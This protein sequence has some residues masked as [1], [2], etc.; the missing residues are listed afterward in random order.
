MQGLEHRQETQASAVGNSHSRFCW[1]RGRSDSRPNGAAKIC[2]KRSLTFRVNCM[3]MSQF[4]PLVCVY[5]WFLQTILTATIQPASIRVY[6]ISTNAVVLAYRDHTIHMQRWSRHH[7][8]NFSTNASRSWMWFPRTWSW[9]RSSD[10][11]RTWIWLWS[12]CCWCKRWTLTVQWCAWR[13]TA[14]ERHPRTKLNAKMFSSQSVSR[15][16]VHAMYTLVLFANMGY[17]CVTSRY[18]KTYYPCAITL[19][20]SI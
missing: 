9:T 3:L 14:T 8:N 13:H 12:P 10:L 19:I 5:T 6:L 11:Q 15:W 20:V 7:S 16:G 17:E 4:S 18:R 1:R 2:S